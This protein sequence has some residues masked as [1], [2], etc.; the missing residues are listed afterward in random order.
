MESFIC[1]TV[2]LSTAYSI[3]SL[4]VPAKSNRDKRT[5]SADK[6]LGTLTKKRTPL[7]SELTIW[8][9]VGSAKLVNA[10]VSKAKAAS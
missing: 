6:L 3:L 4:I 2:W 9:S 10:T 7:V 5:E 8:K 1:T